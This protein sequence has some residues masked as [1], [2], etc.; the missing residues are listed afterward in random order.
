MPFALACKFVYKASRSAEVHG[1][2]HHV[3]EKLV[4]FVEVVALAVQVLVIV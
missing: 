4:V 3:R 1:F 2:S